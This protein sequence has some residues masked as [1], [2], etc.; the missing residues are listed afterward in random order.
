MPWEFGLRVFSNEGYWRPPPPLVEGETAGQRRR[1]PREEAFYVLGWEEMWKKFGKERVVGMHM[2][3]G[4]PWA[5]ERERVR[6]EME[7]G[8]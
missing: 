5:E 6:R 1:R 2:G 8:G 3:E 4:T 7:E